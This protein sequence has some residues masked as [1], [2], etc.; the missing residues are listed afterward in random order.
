MTDKQI[1][2]AAKACAE[3]H[4]SEEEFKVLFDQLP[5]DVCINPECRKE[6]NTTYNMKCHACWYKGIK[7]EL[8]NQENVKEYVNVMGNRQNFGWVDLVKVKG[9]IL[10][11]G[12]G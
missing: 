6:V 5:M 7:H 1:I 11:M 2:I 3:G 8:G 9:C 12:E 10:I 4:L